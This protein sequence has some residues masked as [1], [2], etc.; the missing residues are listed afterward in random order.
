MVI[1]LIENK[2]SETKTE[3]IFRE[4]YEPNTFLE[5]TAIPDVYG[6]KSKQGT[7][8]KGFPDFFLDKQSFAIIVEAKA[9]K[10]SSAEAEVKWYME[11]NL[12]HNGIIGIAI[13]GQELS[14]IKV[15]YYYKETPQSDI[16]PFHIKDKL[17]SLK[18]LEKLF[19]QKFKGEIVSESELTNILKQLNETFHAGGKVRDTDRSLFFSGI[20]IALRNNNFR[21][22][23]KHTTA[24]NVEDTA[25]TDAT[26]LEAH[27]L[28]KS[29]LDAIETE[30]KRKVNNL[31]K[32]FNWRDRFSFISNI[33]YHLEDYI[34]LISL[35]E[36]KIFVPFINNEKLDILGKAY[37]IFLSR[38]GQAENKN[39]ILTPDHIKSLMVKL[40][41]LNVDDVV[42]DT[43]MGSGGFLMEALEILSSLAQDDLEKQD[44]IRQNQLIGFE[45]DSVLFALACSN[46]FLHGDGRSNLMFRSSLLS[47]T[48]QAI[49]NNRDAILLEKIR[50]KKPTKCIIN[51]PYEKTSPIDFTT[52]AIEYLEPNGKLI[53]IMPTPTLRKYQE[54]DGKTE[55]IL[56]MAKLDFVIKMPF[57]LFTEQGRSVNTSIFGFTKTKHNENDEVL[58]YNLEEDGF[59]SI[60]HK[61]RVDVAN[62]WNDIENQIIDAIQNSREIKGISEKRKIYKNSVLN[63]SG[64]IELEENTSKTLV[65]FSDIFEISPK[66][67]LASTKNDP[68]GK[69]DFITA[70][71]E[72]KKHSSYDYDK[73]ALVYALYAAGSLGK[74]Q[75]VNG[76]FTPSNLCV[77]LTQKN[78]K[79]PVNLK[80]YNWYLE[81][82]RKQLVSDLADGTSK[83]TI[84]R[85]DLLP[86]YYIEYFPIEEQDRFVEKYIVPY[87]KLQQ[88]L[89]LEEEKLKDEMS[90]LI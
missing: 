79:Y 44:Y 19:I 12:L 63:C 13:S 80:F 35:I 26:I 74:S 54:V 2:V 77:V 73:E 30:L 89:K 40:A 65:K 51:P 81:A 29:L 70:S 61:G 25:T 10:H 84:P 83:L 86:D 46:M 87:E 6:F 33:D 55:E 85:D 21:N 58:F 16:I 41:R 38:S 37:R 78:E 50:E 32:E 9:L 76:K 90:S 59:E 11:N 34:N 7:D 23:Y 18:N 64:Y 14:Q 47:D 3:N 36:N 43:C 42:I 82:I 22:Q 27:N 20:L 69:Y 17:L 39:I 75:Y 62:R 48:S 57:N 1:S 66:G 45:N 4:F 67:S 28:N 60:Q 72:W 71:D 5:K 52:Q 53:I 24:P 15:T 68:S 31:S 8:Y 56:R 49:V 88:R